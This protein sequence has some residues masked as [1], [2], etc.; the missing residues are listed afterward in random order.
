M[1]PVYLDYN[2]TTPVAPEVLEAMLPYFTKEAG[3]AS[4]IHSF[5]QRARAAVERARESVAGLLGARAAEIVFTSGGTESVN[6]AIF[7]ILAPW[8]ETR[9]HVI[10]SQI[11]HHAVLNTCQALER[12]GVEVTYVPVTADGV[13]DP[14]DVRRALRPETVLITVMHANNELGTVQPIE[15]IGRI[16]VEADVYFHSDAVQSVGKLPIAVERLGV[17]LLSLSGHKLRGPKGVGALYV[18]KGTRLR[19]LFFGGHHERDRRPGTENVTGIVG[20]GRAA[21]L[22]AANL[23]ADAERVAALRDRLERELVA[24]VPH[25]HVNCGRAPRTPNTTN[26][27]FPYVEGEALVIALDLKGVACSTGAACSA[28]AVEPSHVLTA[29]GLAPEDARA[30]LRFSLGHETTAEEIEYALDMV[31]RAVEHLRELSPAYQK[32][33]AVK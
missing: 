16:A 15:E 27:T 8:P 10:T 28:G 22:A 26:I 31:P 13:V 30:S 20:L 12:D 4:S 9:K 11:E 32:P 25:S 21:E 3:N 5:G 7:G 2:S 18:R 33:A 14:A 19:P 23:A 29:I 6:L 24:R 1:K 17:D